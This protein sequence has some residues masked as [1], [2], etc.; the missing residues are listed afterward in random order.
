MVVIELAR[1]LDL[2]SEIS[3]KKIAFFK[4]ADATL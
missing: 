3:P 4:I 2:N 1:S